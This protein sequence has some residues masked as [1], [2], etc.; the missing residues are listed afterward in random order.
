MVNSV[1]KKISAG[2]LKLAV[3]LLAVVVLAEV[4]GSAYVR[5]E[6]NKREHEKLERAICAPRGL[7]ASGCAKLMDANR[8]SWSE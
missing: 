2:E 6:Q 1:G 8:R 7:D 4:A 5:F 3:A